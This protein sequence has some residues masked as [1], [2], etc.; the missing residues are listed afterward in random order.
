MALEEDAH[1]LNELEWMPRFR[2]LEHFIQ[3]VAL[4]RA[5]VKPGGQEPGLPERPVMVLEYPEQR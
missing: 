1:L 4:D 3:M 2:R 5:A